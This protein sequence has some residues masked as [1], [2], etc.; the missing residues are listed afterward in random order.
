MLDCVGVVP[1]LSELHIRG[2]LPVDCTAFRM[3]R[4]RAKNL[5]VLHWPDVFADNSMLRYVDD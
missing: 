4:V 1:Q 5:T 2:H 3:R